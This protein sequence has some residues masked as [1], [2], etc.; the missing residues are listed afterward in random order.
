M[1]DWTPDEDV[2]SHYEVMRYTP[3]GGWIGVQRLLF[4]WTLHADIDVM[5]YARRWCY[6]DHQQA[7]AAFY[8]WD[9]EGDP[10]GRWNKAH[11]LGLRRDPDTGETWPERELQPSTIK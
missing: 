8:A 10:P 2:A 5:G 7:I 4:H 9:G 1:P 11:H 3:H 6:Q